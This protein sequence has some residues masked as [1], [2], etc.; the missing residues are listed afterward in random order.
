VVQWTGFS[1]GR[2]EANQPVFNHPQLGSGLAFGPLDV[3]TIIAVDWLTDTKLV[4]R[5]KWQQRLSWLWW[6]WRRDRVVQVPSTK[7]Y[8]LGDRFVMHRHVY[9]MLCDELQKGDH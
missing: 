6:P 7:V 8:Q 9:K 3:P 2:R 1:A 5:P 4:P